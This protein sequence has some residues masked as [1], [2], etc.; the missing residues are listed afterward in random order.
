MD[1]KHCDKATCEAAIREVPA[2]RYIPSES[3]QRHVAI[4]ALTDALRALGPRRLGSGSGEWVHPALERARAAV[5]LY[6]KELL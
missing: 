3:D 1:L 4:D 2:N 5:S 6:L